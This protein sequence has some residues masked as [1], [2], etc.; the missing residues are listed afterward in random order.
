VS[1]RRPLAVLTTSYPSVA[2]PG[3]GTFIRQFCRA[4]VRAGIP[5]EVLCPQ[6]GHPSETPP[7]AGIRVRRLAYCRPRAWQ[8]LSM[9]PG[10]PDALAASPWAWVPALAFGGRL[11]WTTTRAAASGRY[12]GLVSHWLLPCALA[13]ALGAP[14]ELPHVGIA[15]GSDVHL[16]E[17]LP[18]R[19]A[20]ARRLLGNTRRLVFVSEALRHRF[21]RVVGPRHAD[22]LQR[23]SVVQPMGVMS[24]PGQEEPGRQVALRA[25]ARTRLG[26]GAD[27][28]VLL[29]MGRLVAVKAPARVLRAAAALSGGTLLVA[30]EGPLRPELRRSAAPLGHRVRFVG[31]AEG[32]RKAELL[33]TADVMVHSATTLPDG[34]TDSLPVTVL[35]ALCAGLPVVATA[36]GGLPSLGL[37]ERDGL[38]L[39]R[40]GDEPGLVQAL[41]RAASAGRLSVAT[42]R[43]HRARFGWDHALARILGFDRYPETS[44]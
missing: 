7:E 14:A 40:D 35:E 23:R 4:C 17:R 43:A 39:V 33:A 22:E 16:L 31:F 2:S 42:R 32:A 13:G 3:A 5:V 6:L 38:T 41:Q 27:E 44:E 12:R 37:T 8:F 10:A 20:L 36:L 18:G 26:L 29:W 19:R 11:A 9:A 15:H 28:P 30:G 25:A 34:R 1:E 24:P 21:A